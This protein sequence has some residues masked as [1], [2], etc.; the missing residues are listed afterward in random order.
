MITALRE[1]SLQVILLLGIAILGSVAFGLFMDHSIPS[2]FYS[3]IPAWIIFTFGAG[4]SW[5]LF[6]PL[7]GFAAR[8]SLSDLILPGLR[9]M[10]MGEGIL[11]SGL[12]L[13]TAF[14]CFEP[15]VLMG[16]ILVSNLVMMFALGWQLSRIGCEWRITIAMWLMVQNGLFVLSVGWMTG[17]KGVK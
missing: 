3:K 14:N 12:A 6:L 8:I 9:T 2:M 13:M 11:L 5:A 17:W 4:V 7:L 1:N 10:G 15:R 16:V